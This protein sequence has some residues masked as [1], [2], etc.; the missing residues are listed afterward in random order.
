MGNQ[1]RIDSIAALKAFRA[2]LIQFADAAASAIDELDMELRRS[3]TW[4]QRDR[5]PYWNAKVQQ[6]TQAYTQARIALNQQIVFETAVSGA[7][8]SCIEAREVLRQAQD[9][10]A[11]AQARFERVKAWIQRIDRAI[12]QYKGRVN[13]LRNAIEIE[14]PK[15]VATLDRMV[16]SLQA[17]VD[18]APPEAPLPQQ[19]L[20][21]G[22]ATLPQPD[23]PSQRE[24]E[25]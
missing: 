1:A 10:L 25:L 15:A 22:P 24:P 7:P 8:S 4:L 21:K 20:E 12:S 18:L 6:Y 19:E 3:L 14:I 16:D 11:Q 9:R 17:Y 2:S 23:G 5:Y 13:G